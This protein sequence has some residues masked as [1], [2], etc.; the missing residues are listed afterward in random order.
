MLPY[1][2]RE[3]TDLDKLKDGT[4]IRLAGMINGL[5]RSRPEK[6]NPGPVLT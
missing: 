1:Y 6:G 2:Y 5:K 4:Y 3:I